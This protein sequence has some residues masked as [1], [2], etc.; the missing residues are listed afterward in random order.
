MR[1]ALLAAACA[2]TLSAVLAQGAAPLANV[3]FNP[4]LPLRAGLNPW[5]LSFNIDTASMYVG[6]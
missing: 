3:S 1:R 4:S 2:A 6:D 5:Y